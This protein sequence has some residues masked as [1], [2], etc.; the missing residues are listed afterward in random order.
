[1]E[2]IRV[3]RKKPWVYKPTRLISRRILVRALTEEIEKGNC[4]LAKLYA[5]LL[6]KVLIDAEPKV[7][8]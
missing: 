3:D 4:S 2:R 6:V 5:G 8:V 7:E 1:M